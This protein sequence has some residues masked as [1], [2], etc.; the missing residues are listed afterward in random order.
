MIRSPRVFHPEFPFAPRKLPFFYGWVVV[1][2]STLGMVASIPGQTM[3]VSVFTDHLIAATGLSRLTL[4]YAYLVGTVSSGLL[5]P[6][7]GRL[8]DR[9]GSRAT[10]VL[11][12]LG[13]GLTLLFLSRVDRVADTLGGPVPEPARPWV[14]ILVLTLGF[15]ALRFT[16][17]GMLTLASRTMLGKWFDRRR[18]LVAGVSGVFVSFG[19]S[20]TP[21]LLSLWIDAVGWRGAWAGMAAVAGGATATIV[22]LLFR[23]NPEECGLR[24]DGRDGREARGKEPRPTEPPVDLERDLDRAAALRTSAFW[25]VTLA[26]ALHGMMVTGIS[27]HIVDLGATGGLSETQAV[28]LFLPMSAASVTLQI[29]IGVLADR[30]AVKWLVVAMMANEA[31]ALG[32]MGYLGVPA[33]RWAAVISLGAG[34]GFFTPLS[35]VAL[36]RLFGRT[37]LGS[38]GGAQMMVMVVAS[39]VGPSLL[40]LSRIHEGSY[41]PALHAAAL[42]TLGVA[43]LA[44]RSTR[45]LRIVG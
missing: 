32:C 7:G 9:A 3:G 23:D 34:G 40:A 36:P 21:L 20:A 35:T 8:L 45:P 12:A 10:A 28:A 38:I 39:A 1:G 27:F 11:A 15:V 17:Q 30:V 29:V 22:W 18:G 4:S 43:V 6:R 26:L 42:L 14:A 13:L 37:H 44:A 19:F 2:A 33:L 16:G 5:L 25:A 41:R 31:L 24:M